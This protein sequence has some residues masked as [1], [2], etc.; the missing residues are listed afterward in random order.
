MVVCIYIYIFI[1]IYFYTVPLAWPVTDPVICTFYSY[2]CHTQCSIKGNQENNHF[3]CKAFLRCFCQ[4]FQSVF[5][6]GLLKRGCYLEQQVHLCP[7]LI[8]QKTW[9]IFFSLLTPGIKYIQTI[10]PK[11]LVNLMLV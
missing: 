2:L 6:K 4:P 3:F 1:S 9:V 11:N 10:L 5:P 8:Q 7:G